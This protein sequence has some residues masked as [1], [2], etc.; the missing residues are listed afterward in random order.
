M[1]ERRP[2]ALHGDGHRSDAGDHRASLRRPGGLR[3]RASDLDPPFPAPLGATTGP[4]GVSWNG[5]APGRRKT[6]SCQHRGRRHAGL[7]HAVPPDPHLGRPRGAVR[8]S[9]PPPGAARLQ[10]V[11][12]AIPGG[13]K[14]VSLA[15]DFMATERPRSTTAPTSPS[16]TAQGPVVD[17]AYT[18]SSARLRLD[19]RRPVQH[20]RLAVAHGAAGRTEGVA[21]LLPLLPTRLSEHRVA[22]RERQLLPSIVHIDAIQFWGDG[23]PAQAHFAVRARIDPSPEHGRRTRDSYWTAVTLDQGAFPFGWLFGVDIPP[24]SSSRRSD[25]A[26]RSRARWTPAATPRSPSRAASR[27]GFRSTR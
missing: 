5:A 13:T 19:A 15:W 7:G 4:E 17:L 25:S 10:E 8:R 14:G 18:T 2:V 20:C 21:A 1:L 3:R 11:R 6:R 27:R 16:S 22:G 26:S 24:A 12:V 9:A 23:V